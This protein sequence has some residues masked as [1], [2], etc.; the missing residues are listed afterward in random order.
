MERSQLYLKGTN[1]YVR[2]SDMTTA[3]REDVGD[4]GRRRRVCEIR[5]EDDEQ[6]G[7][8]GPVGRRKLQRGYPCGYRVALWGAD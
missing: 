5:V 6:E 8:M 7:A 4:F 2:P 1:I 3:E